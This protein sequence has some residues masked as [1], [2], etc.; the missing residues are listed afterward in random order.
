MRHERSDPASLYDMLRFA[1]EVATFVEG[2]SWD[3]F[4][5]DVQFRRSV[6]R[7][8]EL[9][10]E[11]ARRVSRQFEAAHP[12]IPWNRIIVQR[13]RLAHEYDT[14][15]DSIIWSVA[16]R[17]VPTLIEQLERLIPPPPPDPEPPT[18]F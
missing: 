6:E 11:A 10:G 13:H 14:I 1:R 9:I 12:E 4:Q 2:R 5:A 16:T 3:H 7:S 15:D 17:Y 8:V 18:T